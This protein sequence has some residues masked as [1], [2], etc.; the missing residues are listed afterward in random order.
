MALTLSVAPTIEPVTLAEVKDHLRIEHT[1]D[2]KDIENFI[3]PAARAWCEVF[4]CRAFI[5][6][7]WVLKLFGFGTTDIVLPKA[8]GSSVSSITYLDS[9]GDSQTWSSSLYTVVNPTGDFAEHSYITP[10]YGEVYPTTRGVPD[11]VTITFVA[12]YGT[13][14]ASVPVALRQGIRLRCDYEYGSDSA[15]LEAAESILWPYKVCRP[16]LRFE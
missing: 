6:Q 12:G 8:P 4:T 13:T 3:M 5:D 16:D 10:A 11:D 9:N 1:Q 7:T 2:D 15:S 14:A